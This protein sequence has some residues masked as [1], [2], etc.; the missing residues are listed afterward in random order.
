[1]VIDFALLPLFFFFLFFLFLFLLNL[2]L[3]MSIVP[4]YLKE[5]T[6]IIIEGLEGLKKM[7][8]IAGYAWHN[9]SASEREHYREQA[10]QL[11]HKFK[12]GK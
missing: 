8:R 1:M 9:L 2:Q 12:D 7:N 3:L 11:A 4:D 6:D 10:N 5:H